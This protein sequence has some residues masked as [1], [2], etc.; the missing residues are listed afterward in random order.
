[1]TQITK[2]ITHGGAYHA[3]EISAIALFAVLND[4]EVKVYTPMGIMQQLNHDAATVMLLADKSE[5]TV[6]IER[7]FNI[8]EAEFLDSSIL[9][10]DIG[11]KYDLENGN[12]DHHQDGTL[13]ASNLM[14]CDYLCM[15]GED[16]KLIDKL[17]SLLFNRISDVDRGIAKSDSWEFNAIIRSCKTF[18]EALK[19]AVQVITNVIQD[20]EKSFKDEERFDKLEIIGNTIIC[21]E[22]PV[23]LGWKELA[24][25]S[26]NYMLCNNIRGGF[27]L[28][29]KNSKK[30]NIPVMD[31]QDFRH[32]SG[33][34][35]VYAKYDDALAAGNNLK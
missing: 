24:P 26:V 18:G 16:A 11:K 34:M 29:S 17:K 12:L 20:I 1:M 28:I 25:E 8:E 22:Q 15:M 10:L 21:I 7:K 2:I 13:H 32:A 33:F 3:D 9:V 23:I 27:N 19:L 14:M 35:A 4:L 5:D 6:V 31:T 30:F